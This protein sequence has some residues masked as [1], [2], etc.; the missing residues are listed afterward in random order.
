ME[1]HRIIESTLR[2]S[3]VDAIRSTL[4][5]NISILSGIAG[6]FNGATT[7]SRGAF[8]TF[9]DSVALNTGQLKGVQG[10]GF[11]RSIPAAELKAYE[12]AIRGQ[13]FAG[14]RVRPAG[15]RPLYS[16]VEYVEP[17]DWRNQRAF[18]FDMT[19][20]AIAGVDNPD[21]AGTGVVIFDGDRPLAD[22]LLYDNLRLVRQGQLSHPSY[23]RLPIG[24]RTWLVGVQTSPRLVSASGISSPFW[25][26]LL[27]GGGLSVIAA[28]VTRILVGYHL[29]TREALQISEGVIRKRAIAGTVFEESGQGI[30]VCNP[31][32]RILTAN[33]AFC[34]LTGYRTCALRG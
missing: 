26:N 12:A 20:S 22:H 6:F 3:V 14:F 10:V 31:E 33:S 11:A 16:A 32:G 23:E 8:R 21:M 1:Q 29:A 25:F 13:G 9:H 15:E 28:L 5:T 4:E 19:T 27:I 17:F 7:V 30:I 24:G 34:K 18:G 2:D